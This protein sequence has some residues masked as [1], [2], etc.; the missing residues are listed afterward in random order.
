VDETGNVVVEVGKPVVEVGNAVVVVEM[1]G[2]LV[3]KVG[4]LESVAETL[5]EH[6]IEVVGP[7]VGNAVGVNEQ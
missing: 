6:G 2:K 3:V 5:G 1:Q 4:R 7:V